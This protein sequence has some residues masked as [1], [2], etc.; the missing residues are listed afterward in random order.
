MRVNLGCGDRYAPGWVNIDHSGMPHKK[1]VTLDL[2]SI[3]PWGDGVL[4]RVY[5]GHVLEHL[6]VYECLSL[7]KRL[8]PCVADDGQLLVVGP[9]VD[10]ALGLQVAGTLDVPIESLAYGAGRWSGDVHRW[11]CSA[12]SIK[13]MLRATGWNRIEQLPWD[14]VPEEWPIAERGPRWQVAVLAMK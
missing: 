11:E 4:Q 8:Q 14:N 5:A 13:A 7:L 2:R 6:R 12:D 3:L 9:D 10:Y 1:D